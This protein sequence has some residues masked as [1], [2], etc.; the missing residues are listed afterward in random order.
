MR[1]KNAR[2]TQTVV[3]FFLGGPPLRTKNE[4]HPAAR[5][6]NGRRKR[7]PPLRGACARRTDARPCGARA[8]A[9]TWE[10]TP[11][12]EREKARKKHRARNAN[13]GLFW[14]GNRGCA[15]K[16]REKNARATQPVVCFFFGGVPPSISHEKNAGSTKTPD[17]LKF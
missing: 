16:M 6:P 3:C 9:S 13:C 7:R 15:R 17:P 5:V 8:D 1:E 11:A 10:E 12:V 4:P 2:A 14:R